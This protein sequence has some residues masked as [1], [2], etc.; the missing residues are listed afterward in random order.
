M[1]QDFSRKIS[2]VVSKSLAPWQVL[3]VVANI[4]AHFGHTLKE[5]YSTGEFFITRDG[6]NIPRNTQYPTIIFAASR[7]Q[8]NKFAETMVKEDIEKMY[9]V[10]EMIET[11]DDNEIQDSLSQKNFDEVDYLGVG[12]FGENAKVKSLTNGLKLWS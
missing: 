3:N 6:K 8:M 11:T 4:A 5:N 2:I 10:E 1:S 9:F 7:E 12:I